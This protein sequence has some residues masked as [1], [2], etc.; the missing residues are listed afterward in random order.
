MLELAALLSP[1][2]TV[3]LAKRFLG[4]D[5]EDAAAVGGTL[6]VWLAERL[7]GRAEARRAERA[8][9]DIADEV[10]DRVVKLFEAEAGRDVQ[11][12]P[13]VLA[14]QSTVERFA[15]SEQV[16]RARLEP[17]K[18]ERALRATNPNATRDFSGP[19][20][21]FYERALRLIAEALCA[22]AENPG[23]RFRQCAISRHMISTC[24][25]TTSRS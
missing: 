21:A 15:A 17:V 25:P 14:L 13:V 2:L 5:T 23:N 8:A 1:A 20:E 18:L 16:V 9:Q 22:V 7:G 3:L 19:Q 10:V 11:A 6:V 12:E 24:S 4:A